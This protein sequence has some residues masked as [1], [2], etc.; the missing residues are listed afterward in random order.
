MKGRRF[1]DLILLLGHDDG[2]DGGGGHVD[3][4]EGKVLSFFILSYS[5][6]LKTIKGAFPK[7]FMFHSLQAI[8]I[9]LRFPLRS[10]C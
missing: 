10:E 8:V 3:D 9:M 1:L 2:D 7:H 5:R 4:V 6:T